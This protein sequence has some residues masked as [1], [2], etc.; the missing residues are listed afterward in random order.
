M[1]ISNHVPIAAM[2]SDLQDFFVE[3]LDVKTV[4]PEFMMEQLAKTAKSR[5]KTA[6]NVKALMLAVSELLDR[7]SNR[8]DFRSSM[9]ALDECSYLP[10]RLAGGT[11]EFRSRSQTFFIVDSEN[12]AVEFGD[13]LV[14]LD[15]SYE[16]LNSLH[17]LIQILGLDDHYLARH[18]NSQTTTGASQQSDVL[19]TQFRQ[20]AY[21][22]SWYGAQYLFSERK[23]DLSRYSCAIAH[24][25]PLFASRNRVLYD[26]LANAIIETSSSMASYL[27][28]MQDGREIRVSTTRSSLIAKHDDEGL[29]ITLPAEQSARKQCMRSQLPGYI[30]A[31]LLDIIDSRGE[32]QIYRILNELETGTDDILLGES[33]SEV[34]WL[35]KTRRPAPISQPEDAIITPPVVLNMSDLPNGDSNLLNGSRETHVE[36]PA[37]ETTIRATAAYPRHSRQPYRALPAEIQHEIDAPDYWKVIEH[38]HRQASKI[39]GLHQGNETTESLD[40]LIA[41]FAA[42][43]FDNDILDPANYPRLFGHDSWLSK[44]RLG[45]AGELLVS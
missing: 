36:L 37:D 29:L 31:D 14:M 23:A 35:P 30:A 32:K 18:V 13:Q 28:V 25:S 2:Y 9:E 24:R 43:A 20:C 11:T 22:F 19:T 26:A 27:V 5:T 38:V 16:Q 10:C 41:R 8:S 4:T 3:V 7:S 12:Y 17:I 15:F 44:F 34:S 42:L 6:E 40:D 1:E 21:A 45:A 39:G 33:I